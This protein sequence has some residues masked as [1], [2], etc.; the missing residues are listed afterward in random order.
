M[1][2]VLTHETVANPSVLA[3]R[4]APKRLLSLG[5]SVW[6]KAVFRSRLFW[7]VFFEKSLPRY[8]V[9][10]SP[11]P[12][13]ILA[14]PEWSLGLSQAPLAM[15][16]FVLIVESYVLSIPSPEKRR[17]L[18][19]EAEAAQKLDLLKVRAR[20]VL[21]ATAAAHAVKTGTLYLV[22]EPS[23]MIRVPPLTLISV[24]IDGDES[25]FV[26]LS[27]EERTHVTETLFAEGLS[28]EDLRRVS[29]MQNT[30]FHCFE[31]DPRDVSAHARLKAAALARARRD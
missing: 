21:S 28:E 13:L 17:K 16:A 8:V 5:V 19:T 10:L 30:L 15:F 18:A 12:F 3:V 1:I 23:G 4:R 20:E 25:G 26:D 6:P 2:F 31:F 27:A 22:V 9:A 29:L 11:F 7:R 14:R 24:Q